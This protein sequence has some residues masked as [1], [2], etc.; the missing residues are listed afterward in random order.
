MHA[1]SNNCIT[2]DLDIGTKVPIHTQLIEQKIYLENKLLCTTMFCFYFIVTIRIPYLA[3]S[4]ASTNV[5]QVHY[6]L[7]L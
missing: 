2:L 5:G 3:L 7:R 1:L 6:L 4:F